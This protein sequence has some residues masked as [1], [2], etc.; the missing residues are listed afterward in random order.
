MVY[1]EQAPLICLRNF[2]D[3]FAIDIIHIYI[4][5]AYMFKVRE[6]NVM[7][8]D[9]IRG[10]QRLIDNVGYVDSLLLEKGVYINS[11]TS[12]LG[13][14][15]NKT[16][17]EE[18]KKRYGCSP[19]E[20]LNVLLAVVFDRLLHDNPDLG[21]NKIVG[22]MHISTNKLR[23]VLED[24][25]SMTGRER[26]K[27]ISD[28][29][30]PDDYGIELSAETVALLD[31]YVSEIQQNID[32]NDIVNIPKASDKVTDIAKVDVIKEIEVRR[33]LFDIIKAYESGGRVLDD[34]QDNSHLLTLLR[35]NADQVKEMTGLD[36]D[37]CFDKIID[38]IKRKHMRLKIFNSAAISSPGDKVIQK[39]IDATRKI[40]SANPSISDEEIFDALLECDDISFKDRSELN[41]RFLKSTSISY[42]KFIS[43]IRF[44]KAFRI[45]ATEYEKPPTIKDLEKI[46]QRVG[47]GSTY[48]PIFNKISKEVGQTPAKF[49]KTLQENLREIL[50]EYEQKFEDY[51]NSY[52]DPNAAF[53]A[54]SIEII[55][56]SDEILEKT[57]LD[58]DMFLEKFRDR[59]EKKQLLIQYIPNEYDM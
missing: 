8:N 30:L 38:I 19:Q 33:A 31:K 40:L 27:F 52:G 51:L 1:R 47:I 14:H 11:L 24:T 37:E 46:S 16:F 49:Y 48:R 58:I 9:N 56:D 45:I 54:L 59:L 3:L 50:N 53:E 22:Y 57:C 34:K 4:I 10:E 2:L 28:N 44:E 25:V 23:A 13:F 43:S 35:Q 18:F 21:I 39:V 32:N 29:G 7:S 41:D 15:D 17:R 42:Q 36:P 5:F 12:K 6:F 55:S 20:R 26:K